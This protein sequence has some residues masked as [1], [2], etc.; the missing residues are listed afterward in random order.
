MKAIGGGLLG[1]ILLVSVHVPVGSASEPPKAHGAAPRLLD[2]WGSYG[3]G[4]DQFIH[5]ADIDLD[6]EGNVFVL[7]SIR[8][9]IRKYSPQGRPL[10]EFGIQGEVPSTAGNPAYLAVDEMDRILILDQHLDC[11]YSY[12]QAGQYLGRWGREGAGPGELDGPQGIDTDQK[13]S[14]YIVDRGNYRIQKF[15]RDGEFLTQWGKKGSAPGEFLEPAGIA[16]DGSGNVYVADFGVG[17]VQKFSPEGRFVTSWRTKRDNSEDFT[18]ALDVDVDS[19][20]HVFLPENH[21]HEVEE[22]LSDGTLVRAWKPS[23]FGVHGFRWPR[24]LAV[25][26][27]GEIYVVGKVDG[28]AMDQA[29]FRLGFGPTRSE[30]LLT[31]AFQSLAS[32]GAVLDTL[33]S[34][35]IGVRW[36]EWT[37]GEGKECREG[38]SKSAGRLDAWSCSQEQAIGTV[39]VQGFTLGFARAP[40]LERAVAFLRLREGTDA[41]AITSS[42]TDVLSR[43]LGFPYED[44]RYRIQ[45]IT[46]P[47]KEEEIFLVPGGEMRLVLAPED[48]DGVPAIRLGRRSVGLKPL[49][50]VSSDTADLRLLEG[51]PYDRETLRVELIRA[52]RHR[53]LLAEALAT[54]PSSLDHLP[55]ID[56]AL[57]EVARLGSDQT[58]HDLVHLAADIWL[59]FLPAFRENESESYRKVRDSLREHGVRI[60]RDSYE[61]IRY[62]ASLLPPLADRVGANEWTDR[63]YVRLLDEGWSSDCGGNLE[64]T[65]FSNM[66]FIPVM[67]R[68]EVFLEA[69]GRSPLWPAVALRVALAHETAWSYGAFTR[70]AA[71]LGYEGDPQ[72]DRRR[73]IELYKAIKPQATDPRLAD[74]LSRRIQLLEQG[75]D[76]GCRVYFPQGH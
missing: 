21:Q 27:A 9:L 1:V 45:G 63:A 40:T 53:P 29:V 23:E 30:E 17:G 72:V 24:C 42:L 15:T 33:I 76:T 32:V 49:E 54:H 57:N 7:D 71:Y 19:Q 22:Y 25:N 47:P 64:G 74:A 2:R 20:N 4:P 41:A 59:T 61:A 39:R 60:H 35:P 28:T 3:E 62:C 16:V 38:W 68:G 11:V 46:P 50:S 26:D 31:D 36:Q 75:T 67:R 37:G 52:L 48:I 56:A 44:I 18:F 14:V 58:E 55:T 34:I 6:R 66:L 12:T 70:H 10:H 13:G 43:R 65:F 73:A 5:V 69:H 8:R 51:M